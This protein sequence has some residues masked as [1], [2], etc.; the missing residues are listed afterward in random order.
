MANHEVTATRF[1][2]QRKDRVPVTTVCIKEIEVI[3]DYPTVAGTKF[4]SSD[5]F[6]AWASTTCGQKDQ[7]SKSTGRQ[8]SEHRANTIVGWF[9]AV[10]YDLGKYF[11]T[12]KYTKRKDMQLLEPEELS[13]LEKRI[14]AETKPE[15]QAAPAP[16][17]A[18]TLAEVY[19]NPELTFVG[20]EPGNTG[21]YGTTPY[22]GKKD[23]PKES[24]PAYEPAPASEQIPIPPAPVQ[25]PEPIPVATQAPEQVPISPAAP[26]SVKIINVAAFF[27]QADLESEPKT[28][29]RSRRDSHSIG[30]GHTIGPVLDRD[31]DYYAGDHGA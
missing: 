31:D 16:V 13:D 19:N 27:K 11:D 3:K 30:E 10:G 23:E 1:Y 26:D 4:Y 14:F 25:A 9:A 17:P 6:Y 21:G 22:D 24:A 8:I 20:P 29:K 5:L 7:C 18:P 15:P 12:P 2:Y 28:P